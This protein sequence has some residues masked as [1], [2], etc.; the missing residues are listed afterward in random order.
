MPIEL[1][2]NAR[3]SYPVLRHQ[4]IGELAQ[5]A[6]IRTEQRDQ[7]KRN[8]KTKQLEKIASGV[9]ADGTTKFRQEL[10]IHAIALPGTTMQFK[11]GDEFVT[12]QAGDR[13]RL[14]LKGL[15]FGR[16]IEARKSHR[17]GKL[18]VGDVLITGTD[19]AQCYDQYGAPKGQPIKTQAEADSVPR[20]TTIG[21]Y[22]PIE[23]A[24]PTDPAWVEAAEQA[25]LADQRAE[26][27]AK[28][29]PAD[30]GD[31]SRSW[32]DDEVAF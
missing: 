19:Q 25:F 27:Q 14:I 15:G 10:V 4:R 30:G 3:A 12:P 23:L 6:I 11:V 31:S 28:A 22:G 13:L 16:F 32:L 26:Q 21:F 18:N 1:T 20:S 5:L 7:L 2:D 29:M 9:R 8:D 17:G 24:E